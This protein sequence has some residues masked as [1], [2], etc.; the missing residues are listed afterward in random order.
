MTLK[1]YL[2][3]NSIIWVFNSDD[4]ILELYPVEEVYAYYPEWL[5]CT[6]EN[7]NI[8]IIVK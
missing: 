3:D 5:N 4:S 7:W 2:N 1:E 8:S 6:V